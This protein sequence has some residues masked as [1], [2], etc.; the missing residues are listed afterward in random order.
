MKKRP[1]IE[2]PPSDYQPTRAEM[3][4]DL[5]IDI[6]DMSVDEAV[7]T[8]LRP[9]EMSETPVRRKRRKWRKRR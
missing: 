8:V 7:K 3:E 9:V 1:V 6:G 2:V 5:G 4:E